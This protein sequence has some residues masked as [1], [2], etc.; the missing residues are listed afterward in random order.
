[1]DSRHEKNY[2]AVGFN[3]MHSA[4]EG[5][6]LNASREVWKELLKSYL[7]LEMDSFGLSLQLVWGSYAFKSHAV[8][9]NSLP[10]ISW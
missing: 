8:Q 10:T 7:G 9:L 3:L 1:M 2:R 4:G 5:G 6:K